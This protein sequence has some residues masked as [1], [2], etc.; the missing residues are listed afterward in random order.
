MVECEWC[1]KPNKWKI[2]REC[3]VANDIAIPQSPKEATAMEYYNPY[4]QCRKCGSSDIHNHY[5]EEQVCT[6]PGCNKRHGIGVCKNPKEHIH[7]YCKCC[8]YT[9]DEAV[10]DAS[11]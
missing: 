8:H 9:W 10:L 2:C 3:R 11:T 1:D 4:A 5:Y 7:R 6:I